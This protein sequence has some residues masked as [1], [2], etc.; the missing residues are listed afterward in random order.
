[1][2]TFVVRPLISLFALSVFALPR[3]TA[4]PFHFLL[5]LFLGELNYI[6][7]IDFAAEVV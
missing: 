1:M 4:H 2:H 3:S 6:F 5:L 7:F